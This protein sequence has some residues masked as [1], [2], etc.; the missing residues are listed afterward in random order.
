MPSII[1]P[2]NCS[3]SEGDVPAGFR[4]AVVAPI[5]KNLHYYLMISKTT[6][7]CQAG[8]LSPNLSSEWSTPN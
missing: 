1:K 4:K 2:V 5:I 8:A 7:L 3:L 6:N